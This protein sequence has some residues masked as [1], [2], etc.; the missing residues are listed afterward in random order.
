MSPPTGCHGILDLLHHPCSARECALWRGCHGKIAVPH[1]DH[2]LIVAGLDAGKTQ[3]E[4]AEDIG[5]S[6][7]HVKP[8]ALV[9][10][11]NHGSQDGS[12]SFDHLYQLVKRGKPKPDHSLRA[13]SHV[14]GRT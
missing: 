2:G 1:R 5:K 13:V 6:Q 3:R 7:S 8:C 12:C 14:R 11:E 9:W 4:V 10:R